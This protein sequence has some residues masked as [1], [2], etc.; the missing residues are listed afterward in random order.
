MFENKPV[1]INGCT[2]VDIVMYLDKLPSNQ[3]DVHLHRQEMRIGGC[4]FNVMKIVK[5]LEIPYVFNS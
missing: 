5:A 3:Q 2:V 1:I 4:A